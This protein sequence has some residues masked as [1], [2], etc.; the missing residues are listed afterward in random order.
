MSRVSILGA[1][2]GR[3]G[4]E[5]SQYGRDGGAKKIQDQNL[6]IQAE[7]DRWAMPA[8]TRGVSPSSPVTAPSLRDG[9]P[10]RDLS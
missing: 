5:L 1:A 8:G 7:S 10:A 3:D 2:D 6:A 4:G 9:Q